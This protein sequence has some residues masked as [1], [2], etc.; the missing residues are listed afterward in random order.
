[1]NP[2]KFRYVCYNKHFKETSLEYLTDDMLLEKDHVPTWITS[3]NCEI[4][5]KQ[6]FTGFKDA[7]GK[8]IYEGDILNEKEPIFDGGH[9]NVEWNHTIGVWEAHY[10]KWI[11]VHSLAGL[12]VQKDYFAV[13]PKPT[14]FFQL[15]EDIPGEPE[16]YETKDSME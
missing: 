5:G 4:K 7:N 16:I 2:I 11:A 6:L 9:W 10:N 3:D 12:L 15:V 13:N 1:M 8:D 14:D